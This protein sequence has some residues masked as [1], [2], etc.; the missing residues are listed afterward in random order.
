MFFLNDIIFLI[1]INNVTLV[2]AVEDGLGAAV[3]LLNS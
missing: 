3:D 2:C 1:F